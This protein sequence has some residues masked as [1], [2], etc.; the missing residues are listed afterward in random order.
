MMMMIIIMK[1]YGAVIVVKSHCESSSGS[2]DEYGMAPSSG[3]PS[4]QTKQPWAVSPPVGCQ[5]P[6][7]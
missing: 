2:Y 3:R 1:V 6:H 7:P 4:D 5:K